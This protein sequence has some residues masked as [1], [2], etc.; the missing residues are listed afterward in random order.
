MSAPTNIVFL[1]KE[2]QINKVLKEQKKEKSS[3]KI[4]FTSL[5]DP[6]SKELLAVYDMHKYTGRNELPFTLY[7]VDSF[8]MPHSFVIFKI[9]NTPALVSIDEDSIGVETYLPFIYTELGC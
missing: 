7:V 1:N 4:L 9:R 8:N 5:W 3:I 2:N 6:W